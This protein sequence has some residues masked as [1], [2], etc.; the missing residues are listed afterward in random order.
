[1]DR[2]RFLQCGALLVLPVFGR[3]VCQT[4]SNSP[5]QVKYTSTG[6]S[7]LQRV[8]DKYATDYIQSGHALG[9]ITIR[10][11]TEGTGPWNEISAASRDLGVEGSAQEA[12]A[13]Y[14]ISRVQPTLV[15]GAR[16]SASVSGPGVRVLSAAFEPSTSHDIGATRFIW[17]AKKG[18]SEWVEYDFDKPQTIHS[19]EVFWAADAG[20]RLNTKLPV[21]WK[22][23]YK[24]G[25]DWKD[26]QQ[27]KQIGRAHV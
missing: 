20:R 5:F 21:A 4:P 14:T 19:A 17:T 10:Y 23:L 7:S 24:A 11:R 16:V 1:M 27:E 13:A 25:D 12:A 2:R 8:Q 15:G 26:V 3:V 6:V 22:I 18:S 9:D